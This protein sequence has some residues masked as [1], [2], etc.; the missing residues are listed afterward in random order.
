[1]KRRPEDED[2]NWQEAVRLTADPERHGHDSREQ[3]EVPGDIEQGREGL[4]QDHRSERLDV[5]ECIDHPGF[6]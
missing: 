2:R 3:D 5:G 1:M 4:F 6:G